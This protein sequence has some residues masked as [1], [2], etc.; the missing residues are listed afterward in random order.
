MTKT[1]SALRSANEATSDDV[2]L[3]VMLLSFYENSV[4]SSTPDVSNPDING[5]ASRP[6][7]HH[8]GAMAMLNLRRQQS[9]RTRT[10]MELDKLIRRQMIR[11]L[12]LRSMPV[13]LWLRDGSKFGEVGIGLELDRCMV[14]VA[15]LQHQATDLCVVSP[16]IA[17]DEPEKVARLENLLA[18]ARALDEAFVNWEHGLPPEYKYSTHE[19]LKTGR[20]GN[21]SKTLNGTVH[22]YLTVGHA[23]MWNRYRALRLS[24]NDIIVK[25]LARLDEHSK[26]GMKVAAEA[27]NL[28]IQCVADDLCASMPYMLGMLGKGGPSKPDTDV[29]IRTSGSLK[30]AVTASTASFLCWPLS[31]VIKLSAIPK[32]QKLYFKARLLDLS[33]IVDDGLL[34]RLANSVSVE[35]PPSTSAT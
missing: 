5:I 15:K 19:V 13:P 29:F 35:E 7:A 26:P 11:S 22:I 4:T 3:A 16:I 24:V 25:T 27:A 23:G 31:V 17:K 34:E 2:L 1:N 9:Q 12:L 30:D 18:E 28:R 20:A 14:I 6:F 8:D 33:E 21:E 10:S 32:R